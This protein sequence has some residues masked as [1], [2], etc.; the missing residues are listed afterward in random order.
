[1]E[2]KDQK[3]DESERGREDEK[4]KRSMM[5]GVRVK[6]EMGRLLRLCGMAVLV[7][8]HSPYV[9]QTQPAAAVLG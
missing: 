4:G 5:E 9:A 3:V 1:M 7:P 6:D 8:T 2:V